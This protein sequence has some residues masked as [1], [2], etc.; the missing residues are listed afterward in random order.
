M[1]EKRPRRE[2]R[3]F[4]GADGKL[5]AL[6]V[7]L[8]KLSMKPLRQLH[9]STSKDDGGT[10]RY[11]V[12][13]AAQMQ[14]RG[15]HVLY[16]CR[17]R[18]F[19]E[20]QCQASGVAT[21]PLRIHNSGDFAAAM[22]IAFLAFKERADVIHV[23][24]RSDF[25]M[26][27]LGVS[28]ARPLFR[29][30][31]L[32][33]PALILHSHVMRPLGA[34]HAASGRFFR[35]TADAA[36]AVS[37][38]GRDFL[39]KTH[40]LGSDFVR[41]LLNGVPL[42]EYSAPDNP[43]ARAWRKERRAAWG[44]PEDVFVLGM[45]GRLGQKGQETLLDILPRLRDI[46]P[47][48]YLVLVGPETPPLGVERERAKTGEKILGSV[49]D[50]EERAAQLGVAQSVIVTGPSG[51]I[52]AAMAA[53]DLFVHVPREE[54]FGLALVEAMASGLPLVVSQVG[55]CA[56]VAEE[57]VTALFV[58]AGDREALFQTLASL[59]SPKGEATR[60]RLAAAGPSVAARFSLERQ[61][62]VLRELYQ[63]LGHRQAAVD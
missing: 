37:D 18:S 29:R 4:P 57:N 44:V 56:E 53:F 5:Y 61:T 26:A 52:P 9:I 14:A 47:N 33:R 20:A 58:P 15:D 19:T 17:A 10:D 48:L 1:T 43:R 60:R 45:V 2:S 13:L 6:P 16:A 28:M 34:P 41:V 46:H 11:S 49:A 12:R 35:R 59:I 51:A 39:M 7:R 42:S 25:V 38:A 63:E 24:R 8:K 21:C 62:E 30:K 36:L 40:T 54:A 50:Y 22:R 31:H 55:G 23:H 27:A 32:P 3:R